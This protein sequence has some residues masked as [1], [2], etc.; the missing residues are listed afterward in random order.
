VILR[1]PWQRNLAAVWIAQMVSGMAFS[2]IL[3]FIPLYIQTLG[4]QGTTEAAQWAGLIGAAAAVSMTV[5]QPIW[6]NLADR[7]GRRPMVLRSTFGGCVVIGLM[8]FATSPEQLLVLRFLQ[9]TITGVVAAATALVATTTPKARLGFTLGMMQVALFVGNSVGPL[10][11]GYISDTFGYRAAFFAASAF[12]L[13]AG[14][15]VVA[16]VRERFVRPTK[17]QQGPGI[18]AGSRAL[19][20]SQ[21]FAVLVG[22]VF[23]I[24]LAGVIVS[25]VLTL[26]IADLSGRENAATSA[27]LVLA[28]TGVVSAGSAVFFGRLS[29]RVGHLPILLVCLLGAAVSYFPQAL[30]STTWQL[31][32]LR[33]A[34]GLF[35]GGLMPSANALVAARVP[36][37]RRGSAF[38]LTA[39]AGSFANGVGPLAG[40]AIATGLGIREVFVVT[41]GLFVAC[42]AWSL[43][44][45]RGELTSGRPRSPQ[46]D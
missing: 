6:G 9:G 10:V 19:L 12:L 31:L 2:F 8:G 41:G 44:G 29:D 46:A 14:L 13:V 24:Q 4:V 34:L 18:I 11:G 21:A 33:M 28:A 20:A 25:P 16:F 35:L 36:P 1:E 42:W 43:A 40:A 32:A 17:E 7:Y 23:M 15:I 38:G 30:V 27:G 45:L 26:F 39:M 22:V 3:P 37:E 5:V